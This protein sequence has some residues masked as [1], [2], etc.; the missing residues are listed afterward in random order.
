MWG[1]PRPPAARSAG[2]PARIER[3][4]PPTCPVEGREGF[5]VKALEKRREWR[6]GQTIVAASEANK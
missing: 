3:S 6:P 2:D 5:I 1:T 4:T